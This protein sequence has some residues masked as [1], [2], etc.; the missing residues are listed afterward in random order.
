M[1]KIY[2]P[3]LAVAVAL[4]AAILTGCIEETFPTTVVTQDQVINSPAAAA[5]Y[6]MGMPAFMNTYA[7]LGD[8]SLHFDFGM[9]AMM[10][11]RD[12]MTGDMPILQSPSGYDWFDAWEITEYQSESNLYPQL[13]WNT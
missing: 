5:S 9:P 2:M 11:I 8:R 12:V 10:H 6:A 13:I 1:K 4:P 7:V 3:I